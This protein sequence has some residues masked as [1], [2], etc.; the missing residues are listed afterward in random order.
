MLDMLKGITIDDVT[1]RD[2]DDAIWVENTENGGWHVVV[3][4]SD[5]TKVVPAHSELDRIAMS[6][7]ETRYYATG[8]SPMLPRRLADEKLSLWPGESKYVLAV[9]IILGVDLSVLE[10]RLSWTAMTSEAR[11]TFSDIPR[12]LSDREHPQHTLIKLASQLA[13]G[14]LTQRRNRGA[15]AFCDLSRG[16]VTSEEGSLRQLRRREDTI[17]YVIIQELMILAN[18]TVAEYAIIND[19]PILFRNHTAR[20]ATPEREDLLKLLESTAVVPEINI[21]T[22]GHTTYM[23]FNRAE[24]A[25]TILGHFGLNIGVYTHFTSPIRRYADLVNHQQIRAYIRNEPLPH[26]KE[27][28][29]AIA[30][31]V[32]LIH[33]ENDKAKSEYMKEKAYRKAESAILGNRIE[34]ASDTDFERITK[35][36]I[37]KGEDCPETYCDAFRKRLGKL[38]IICAGLVLLQAPD[39]ERWTELKKELLEEMATAPHRATSIFDIAQHIPG[40]QMPVFEVNETARGNLP[41]FTARSATRVGDREYR[42]AAYEDVTKKGAVQRASVDL[43][44]AIAGLPAPDLKA[45]IANP[46]ASKEEMTINTSK[47]PIFA[48]QE[49]CQAKKLPLPAYS[50]KTEGPTNKPIFT[51]TCTFGSSTSTEQAGKKQRAKRLAARA[52]IYTLVSGN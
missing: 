13:N 39:G 28:I 17:G 38:P 9:D 19:I 8:N 40:W 45:T 34:D 46:P 48:L 22:I 49:Y 25:P 26:S 42:S 41:V 6:R 7:V 51:C 29:Q 44:A 4:I 33:L 50:F 18:M 24:Y 23:M 47:D 5:V 15:L 1:T 36:L 52:M 11:L 10:T 14:L 32:N 12:I 37:R 30:S 31:H 35:V 16:L 43:L 20:S 2:M 21:A 27:E 3:M